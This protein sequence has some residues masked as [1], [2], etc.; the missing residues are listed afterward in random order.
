MMNPQ[1]QSIIGPLDTAEAKPAY[2]PFIREI[3]ASTTL[4]SAEVEVSVISGTDPD[5]Q[6]MLVGVPLID[7]DQKL[8]Q[9]KV[10]GE[11]RNGNTYNIRCIAT[12]SL[13][14]INTV[15]AILPVVF[16]VTD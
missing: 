2:F 13:G 16:L 11:G 8:V 1:Q 9:Q 5:P 14:N 10:K 12:D 6:G 15:A 7:N 3:A 4:V